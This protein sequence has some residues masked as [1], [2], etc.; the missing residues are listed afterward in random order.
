MRVSIQGVRL[1]CPGL[2]TYEFYENNPVGS[3]EE[4]EESGFIDGRTVHFKFTPQDKVRLEKRL[5]VLTVLRGSDTGLRIPLALRSGQTVTIG[6][7][8]EADLVFR[9]D[10]ISRRHAAISF[11]DEAKVYV[12]HD[13]GSTNGTLLNDRPIQ[14]AELKDGDKIFLGGTIL[15]FM[16]QDEVE[17][18]S[19]EIVDRLFFQDDLTGL[20][21]KRLFY[22]ELEHRL[23]VANVQSTDVTVLMMDMDGLKA[24]NDRHGHTMGAFVISEVGKLIGV[25]CKDLGQACRFGGD[26]FIAYLANT[27]KPGA[28]D[29]AEEIRRSVKGH[30]FCREGIE[31]RVS[32]SIGVAAFPEDGKNLNALVKAADE[33]LYRAKGKGRN[34]VSL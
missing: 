3:D 13:L 21:V 24:V 9:D 2:P 19:G 12:L 34:T 26:E 8:V 1:K 7:T 6:R 29:V 30:V 11:D 15:K 5:P 23:L 14:Q 17:S 18:E 20:V 4:S 31:V 32:I 33:A 25:I 28:V 27:S 10:Q 22:K 16:L